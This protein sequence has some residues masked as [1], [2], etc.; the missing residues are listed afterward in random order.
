MGIGAERACVRR[1]RGWSFWARRRNKQ[2]RLLL[3]QTRF[4]GACFVQP[5]RHGGG[6]AGDAHPGHTFGC[7]RRSRS[8][9]S[10][11]APCCGGGTAVEQRAGSGARPPASGARPPDAEASSSDGQTLPSEGRRK[12]VERNPSRSRF[13]LTIFH[14]LIEGETITMA[15]FF[16]V[17]S[18]CF[19]TR[20][21]PSHNLL[22]LQPDALSSPFTS[23]AG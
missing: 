20:T 10:A 21:I 1:Q 16:C 9:A 6:R 22:I 23:D 4:G 5:L 19:V 17:F 8:A 7:K 12:A 11:A 15:R 13:Q 3:I 2:G 18:F 14:Q